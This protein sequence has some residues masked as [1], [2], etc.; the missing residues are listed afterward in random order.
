VVAAAVAAVGGTVD[1]AIHG[2][3]ATG[4]ATAT[5]AATMPGTPVR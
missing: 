4:A 2:D 5:A 3:A 1:A